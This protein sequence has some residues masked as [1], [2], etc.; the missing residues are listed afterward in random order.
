MPALMGGFG[1]YF[2]PLLIG[3]PDKNLNVIKFEDSKKQLNIGS[4]LAGLWE[5]DGHIIL[6]KYSDNN[7]LITYPLIAITFVNKDLP[8]V[9]K[10]VSIYGGYIRHKIKEN[11]IVWIIGNK[12]NLINIVELLNSY[13]R[14]P[15]LYEFNLLIDYLN[16]KYNID[17]KKYDIDTSNLTNNNWLAGFIDADG[18][19]KIKYTEKKLNS[20]GFVITKER[21]GISFSI[22]QRKIH[23][24]S[25]ERFK[26]I[27]EKINKIFSVETNLRTSY[28]NNKEYWIVE[29]SSLNKLENLIIYLN[30][31]PLLTAKSNDYNDWLK[32]YN[33]VKE[34]EHLTI[35]GKNIIKLIKSG[36]NKNRK[37]FNWQH[38][39]VLSPL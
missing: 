29:I 20:K 34:K 24:K 17:I 33:L 1:N 12:I 5:G 21:I 28:H 14:T 8:L 36:F 18:S 4:Y 7:K 9:K 38:L 26:D 3:A 27:M 25:N 37:I 13:I 35:T 2:V 16:K 22:E 11:A 19:F 31:F 23:L 6:P 39:D 15:K 10:L 32:V 30:K